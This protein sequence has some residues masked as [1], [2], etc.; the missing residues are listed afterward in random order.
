MLYIKRIYHDLMA[1]CILVC[2]YL[3]ANS[4][5]S[6]L[7]A[8]IV[9]WSSFRLVFTSNFKTLVVYFFDN[10]PESQ[11]RNITVNIFPRGAGIT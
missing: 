5:A 9:V 3:S 8:K 11:K 10:C 2:V 7:Q 6:K 4:S 1:R